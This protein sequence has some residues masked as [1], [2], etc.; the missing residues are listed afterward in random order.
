MEDRDDRR[1]V[2]LV[3]VDQQLHRLDLV[4]QVEV[5][6]RLVEDED[7]RGLGDGHRDEHQLPLAERQLACVA[8]E[9]VADPD[10]LDRGG[11]GGPVGRARAAE[12]VLVGQP[13]ERHDLLDAGRE[14]QVGGARHDGH[15]ARDFE[16]LE[17]VD[18]LP[19]RSDRAAH[20]AGAGRSPPPAGST[21]RRRSARSG[22]PARPAA[23][24]SETSTE[25]PPFAVGGGDR[26]ELDDRGGH[27]SYPVRA[28]RRISRK[29][30]APMMAVTTPTGMPP[31][32]RA[33]MSA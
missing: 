9:Q 17:G 5:D 13:A 33:R 16:P 19:S 27:T 10:A 28:R 32:T 8:A 1:P 29:N 31:A 15:P 14:R 26:V 7:R 3:E 4:A 22:R 20:A 30:G 18:R 12:R 25:D 21:S 6:G 24:R 23:I 2:A 11:D